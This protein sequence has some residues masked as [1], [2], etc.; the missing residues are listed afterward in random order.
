MLHRDGLHIGLDVDGVLADY[1]GAAV[2]M[3]RAH[4]HMMSGASPLNYGLVEPGW[5]P[6]VA[7]AAAAMEALHVGGLADLALFDPTAPQAVAQLRAA[8]HRVTVVTARRP[9]PH[10]HASLTRW[11]HRHGIEFDDLHF[12]VVK[13][14]SGCD[15]YLDDAPHNIV[16]IRAAGRH[17]VIRDTTYNR[18]LDGL[19]VGSLAEFTDL[20]RAGTFTQSVA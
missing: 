18:H 8:G 14:R 20:V 17:G 9:D 12:E 2:E 10:G 16:E 3:G 4:G 7:A 11:L 13:S 1:M 15:V 5:F 19:R 6:D